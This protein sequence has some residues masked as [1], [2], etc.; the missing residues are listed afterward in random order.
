MP[1]CTRK[2]GWF[3]SLVA[4]ISL[5]LPALIPLYV[6]FTY[7]SLL[8]FAFLFLL[9]ANYPTKDGETEM[10]LQPSIGR[11]VETA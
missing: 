8:A 2:S 10:F 1:P 9:T 3:R 4:F 6:H 5:S 11:L 7:Y